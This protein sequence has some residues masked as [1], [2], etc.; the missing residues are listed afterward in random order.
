MTIQRLSQQHITKHRPTITSNL[1]LLLRPVE[2]SVNQ[3]SQSQSSINYTCKKI[4]NHSFNYKETKT[5]S[6][7]ENVDQVSAA[8]NT[9]VEIPVTH[10]DISDYPTHAPLPHNVH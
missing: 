8:E 4:N 5:Q 6:K 1:C 9:A 3:H 2:Y 10:A 7:T